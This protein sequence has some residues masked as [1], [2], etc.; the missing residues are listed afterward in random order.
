MILTDSLKDN[1]RVIPTDPKIMRDGEIPQV[2]MPPAQAMAFLTHVA[3]TDGVNV[4]NGPS[5]ADRVDGEREM[6]MDDIIRNLS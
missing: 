4:H 6:S 1:A 5:M 3:T 2:T